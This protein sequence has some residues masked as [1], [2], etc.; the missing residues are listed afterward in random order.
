MSLSALSGFGLR[1]AC[2]V[3]VGFDFTRVTRLQ[4]TSVPLSRETLWAVS[5]E[6]TRWVE[7]NVGPSDSEGSISQAIF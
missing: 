3:D 4:K 5:A 1:I 7:W 6:R 2:S